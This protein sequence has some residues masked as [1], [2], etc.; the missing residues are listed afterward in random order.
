VVCNDDVMLAWM[1]RCGCPGCAC[2]S[3][4]FIVAEGSWVLRCRCKH[5]HT[6][7]DPVTRTCAKSGCSCVA[8]HS[9]WVCNCDHPWADHEQV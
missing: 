3:F 1:R 9:P 6:E 4:F 2:A 7:H 5:R 8:F